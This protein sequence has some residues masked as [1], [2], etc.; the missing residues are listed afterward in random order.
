MPSSFIGCGNR[1]S[2]AATN[3]LVNIQHLD[4]PKPIETQCVVPATTWVGTAGS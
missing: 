1:Y 2:N 3:N 4:V